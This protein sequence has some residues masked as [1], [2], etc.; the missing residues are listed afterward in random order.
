MQYSEDEIRQILANKAS[1]DF[2]F[3][4]PPDVKLIVGDDGK[5]S[6]E[7]ILYNSGLSEA[8]KMES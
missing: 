3:T 4:A 7:V 2:G 6:A 1:L 5:I 8:I